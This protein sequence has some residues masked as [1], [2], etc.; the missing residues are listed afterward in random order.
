[1]KCDVMIIKPSETLTFKFQI[2]PRPENFKFCIVPT[3]FDDSTVHR[4][5]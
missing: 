4:G 3:C 1:M 2:S 5:R